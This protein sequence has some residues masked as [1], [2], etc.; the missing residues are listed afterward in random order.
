M[1]IAFLSKKRQG[2][3]GTLD[4]SGFYMDR[5]QVMTMSFAILDDVENYVLTHQ[6]EFE[7][8]LKNGKSEEKVNE[9]T[10]SSE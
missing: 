10:E 8:F 9:P 2:G 7:K 3:V 6:K 4:Y 5:K 1:R